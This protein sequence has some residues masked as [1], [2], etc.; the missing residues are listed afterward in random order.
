M[1]IEAVT[2]E[3]DESEDER[4]RRREWTKEG[5]GQRGATEIKE[6]AVD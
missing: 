5:T 4:T 1:T 3:I 2:R 6:E